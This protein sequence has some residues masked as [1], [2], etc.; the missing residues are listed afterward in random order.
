M[1][2]LR[3]CFSIEIECLS[4]TRDLN[5]SRDGQG[6]RVLSEFRQIGDLD[7]ILFGGH[8]N[9]TVGSRVGEYLIQQF[10]GVKLL[11][12]SR[13]VRPEIPG[14]TGHI[15]GLDRNDPN[16]VL[17]VL[18]QV[19]PE[20]VID[21]A[22]VFMA[23]VKSVTSDEMAL[24]LGRGQARVMI[25][26]AKEN[27]HAVYVFVSSQ[28]AHP[29]VWSPLSPEKLGRPH[30]GYGGIP[31]RYY[32]EAKWAYE[33]ALLEAERRGEIRNFVILRLGSV[34]SHSDDTPF[35]E[36][37]LESG[38]VPLGQNYTPGEIMGPVFAELIQKILRGDSINRIYNI[39]S[40]HD[41]NDV[42]A[43]GLNTFSLNYYLDNL[44][45]EKQFMEAPQ[46]H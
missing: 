9:S 44:R 3:P 42:Q 4:L 12:G 23:D 38:F 22:A 24:A 27:P 10:P 6:S 11:T 41:F 46:T 8:A 31:S 15:S 5:R 34:L 37:A 45:R 13:K 39:S 43:L 17:S 1:V 32:G 33:E 28:F 14:S 29:E 26:F 21:A 36:S 40:L 25:D 7:I 30:K 18:N 16:R 20:V 35:T 2:T 19:R